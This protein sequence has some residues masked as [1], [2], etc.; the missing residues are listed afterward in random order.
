MKVKIAVLLIAVFFMGGCVFD[1][2]VEE[3]TTSRVLVSIAVRNISCEVASSGDAELI[4][5]LENL[6]DSVKLGTI[7][8]G[9]LA[10]L[11]DLT[12]DRPTLAA[13]L[14]DLILLL[15]VRIEGESVLGIEGISPELWATIEKAWDQGQRMCE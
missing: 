10:Q 3:D 13:D 1:M 12:T 6:Y 11:S 15:G 8:D 4:K 7:S 9:L 14:S 2:N 5:T